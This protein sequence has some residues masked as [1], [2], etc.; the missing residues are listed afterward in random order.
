VR[1]LILTLVFAFGI[2]QTLRHAWVGALLWTWLSLMNPHRLC[3]GFAQDFPFAAITAGA[4]MLSLLWQRGKVKLPRET[5]V[6]L[7][8]L[9]VVWTCITTV[10][11][12]F[13]ERSTDMLV[14]VVKVQVMTLVCMAVLRE[15]KHIEYFVWVNV[16]S[17][18]FYGFKGGIFAIGSGGSSRVWGPMGTFIEDNNALGLALV[19]T[20]PFMNYLRQTSTNGW[21]R[22]GFVLLMMLSA[23]SALASQSRGAFLAISAMT[24]VMWL[25][26]RKKVLPAI[27]LVAAGIALISFM[28]DSWERRM[29]TIGNYEQDTSAMQ[30]INAWTNAVRVAGDRVTGAGFFIA[31]PAI[32]ARYAPNPEWVHTAHSIYFQVLGEHGYTGLVLFL[33]LG[34][35][36]FWNAAR[37][38]KT[39]LERPETAWVRDLAGMAQVSMVGYAVGGAFLSLSYFDLPYNVLVIIIA[40]KVWVREERWKTDPT[41]VPGPD[42]SKAGPETGVS[43]PGVTAMRTRSQ[44]P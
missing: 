11:A 36:G 13:P 16:I 37:L 38:R 17:L 18:G 22:K 29:Q 3:Y 32:F 39:S 24:L 25:R 5:T 33:S 42:V 30:R 9:F 4:T 23:V 34:F 8:I 15:R 1:D 20:I 35:M 12:I 26:M 27:V 14:R 44:R 10:L 21:V 40:C 2:A 43:L 6:V 41:G 19:M 28:P 31:T 7:I